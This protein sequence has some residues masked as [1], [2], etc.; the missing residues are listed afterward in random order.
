[1]KKLVALALCLVLIVSLAACSN[2]NNINLGTDPSGT[3]PSANNPTNDPTNSN[4]PT[5]PT[6]NNAFANWITM[7]V[8]E[9]E[10]PELQWTTVDGIK[11]ASTPFA[12]S[13]G[14]LCA[15]LMESNYF[16]NNYEIESGW[17]E[18]V[19]Y[20]DGGKKVTNEDLL[21]LNAKDESGSIVITLTHPVNTYTSYTA[22][23]IL[24]TVPLT[25]ALQTELLQM[26][27]K[28]GL[29]FAAFW[30]IGTD[31]DQKQWDGAGFPGNWDSTSLCYRKTYEDYF[32]SI[33]RE[34][35]TDGY[36][37]LYCSLTNNGKENS[38]VSAK[39]FNSRYENLVPVKLEKF[40][41]DAFGKTDFFAK[42]YGNGLYNA[43]LPNNQGSRIVGYMLESMSDISGKANYTIS[44]ISACQDNDG[45]D[46]TCNFAV[47]YEVYGGK[48]TVLKNGFTV[49]LKNVGDITAD[50]Y[51]KKGESIMGYM[52]GDYTTTNTKTPK[53][54]IA[55]ITAEYVTN[56]TN[57]SNKTQISFTEDW[58]TL[59]MNS[60]YMM[61][62]ASVR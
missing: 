34:I 35:T 25:G 60:S 52:L 43:I 50:N 37:K 39:H 30:L 23:D 18:I 3:T 22:I 12:I 10:L 58:L 15:Y 62:I 11:R 48:A 24:C 59:T 19:Y 13:Y 61:G 51:L 28:A 32:Y 44:V 6:S 55:F 21:T 2:E 7:E 41:P 29:S 5:E 17:R 53:D 40:L 56:N 57:L 33:K 45:R 4:N 20:E 9:P 36:S 14:Q 38:D 1:M 31:A 8:A 16:I 26:F 54:N 27:N 42:E 46:M 49:N 47:T